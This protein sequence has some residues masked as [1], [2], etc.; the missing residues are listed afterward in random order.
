MNEIVKKK[1]R[2]IYAKGNWKEKERRIGGEKRRRK[3]EMKEGKKKVGK[4][5]RKRERLKENGKE[6][7]KKEKR[8]KIIKSRI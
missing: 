7:T 1:N 5:K 3:E 2:F 4:R 8:K 6:R